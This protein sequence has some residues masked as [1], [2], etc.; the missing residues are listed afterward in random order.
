[1][2]HIPLKYLISTDPLDRQTE[3]QID[4]KQRCKSQ[5]G[6]TMLKENLTSPRPSNAY[7]WPNLDDKLINHKFNPKTLEIIR[8]IKFEDDNFSEEV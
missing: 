1:M 2:P 7:R 8:S 4:I 3:T 5:I 6:L